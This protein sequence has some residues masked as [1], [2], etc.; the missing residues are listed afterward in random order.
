MQISMRLLRLKGQYQ[1][2]RG[3][4]HGSRRQ[5]VLLVQRTTVCYMTHCVSSGV[6]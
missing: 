1:K 3:P 5:L 6:S 4:C 2:G